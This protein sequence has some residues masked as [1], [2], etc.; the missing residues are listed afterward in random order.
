[1]YGTGETQRMDYSEKIRGE[2]NEWKTRMEKSPGIASELSRKLQS[3]INRAIPER[4]HTA[5]T[6]AIRQMTKTF[7]FGAGLISAK[8]WMTNDDEARDM[9]IRD[10]IKFYRNAAAAEGAI[11]GAGGILLGLADFPIWLALK[12]KMLSE[13]AS[14]YGKDIS[15]LSERVF[16]L[17]IFELTFSS[18]RQRNVVFR[19]IANW[20]QYE[21]NIPDDINAFDWRRFQQ[22]YRDYIDIAKMLQLVPGIG[23]AV[24]AVVNHRL[25][26]KLGETAMNAYRLRAINEKS[27]ELNPGLKQLKL[28]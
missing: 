18:Q 1:L 8:P 20:S 4:V 27:Q 14:L 19:I 28:N 7:L 3:R 17:Y 23:A 26:T 22:E 24:G 10:R 11:T 15:R 13:I 9:R 5:I 16:I 2:V 25:T 21:Q 12:I 6:S